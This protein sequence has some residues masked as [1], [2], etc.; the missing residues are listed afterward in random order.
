[1]RM[2][3]LKAVLYMLCFFL[4]F[5]ACKKQ[6]HSVV[7]LQQAQQIVEDDPSGA[8]QLLDSISDPQGM[9]KDHYMQYIVAKVHAKYKT[10]Q[11]ITQDTL[12]FEAC[13]YFDSKNNN[14]Q[15]VLAHYYAS[16][17]YNERNLFYK[18]FEQSLMAAH[19]AAKTQDNLYLGK[20]YHSIGNFYDSRD[21]IDSALVSFKKAY[22]YYDKVEGSDLYKLEIE[23]MFGLV[24]KAQGD[25]D[26]AYKHLNKGFEEAKSLNNLNYQ[27][28]FR[29]LL[30]LIH[31]QKKEYTEATDYLRKA[32]ADTASEDE[33][34]RICLTLLELYNSKN[35]LD[36]AG[37]YANIL[38]ESLPQI[39]YPYT[40]RDSYKFISEYYK[41]TGDYQNALYYN[42]LLRD[43]EKNIYESNNT[44]EISDAHQEYESAL[45]KKEAAK[46]KM[47]NNLILICVILVVVLVIVVV[48]FKIR[49]IRQKSAEENRL[50]E[51]R[52]ETQR[53]ELQA[54]EES[55][56]R[57]N[58]SLSYMQSTYENIIHEWGEIDKKVKDLTAEYGATEE[59]EIYT[60]IKKLIGSFKQNTNQHLI[61]LAKDY[62]QTQPYGQAALD[63]LQEKELLIFMLY[64]SGYKRKEVAVLL[65][66][67]PHKSNMNF[68]K[69]GVKTKLIQSGMPEDEV[70]RILFSEDKDDKESEDPS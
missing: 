60:Q 28:T 69:L 15:S 24:Y 2:S 56:Q 21:M 42:N 54:Q 46:V 51:A 65:G 40:L 41:K 9:D 67:D 29:H 48:Y 53:V 68:R 33:S 16:G 47:R 38:K 59:P 63:L 12:I 19:Y 30:G 5:Y 45:A 55:M 17:V 22:G 26:N 62:L 35:Q 13:K 37:Y 25:W 44:R 18:D 31:I 6:D 66:V 64:Y 32:F 4:A 1:M 34:R 10:Y 57:R 39:T 14:A 3:P 27:T 43:A 49:R 36:S 52:L 7:L 23:R 8:L 58:K 20:S 50:L 61:G 70:E 11:D